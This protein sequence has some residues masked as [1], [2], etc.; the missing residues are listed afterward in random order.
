MDE[1]ISVGSGAQSV[2]QP[3]SFHLM[4]AGQIV[5][6]LGSSLLRF[7]LSLYVLDLTGRADLFATL[8][9]IS[10]IPLLLAPIGGAISD[11]FN[12]QRLMVLYDGLCCAIALVFLLVMGSGNA[13]VFAIGVVMVLLGIVGA[14][15]T[16]N[17]TACVPLLVH[18][19]KLESSNGLIQ[20]VQSLSGIIAPVLGGIL[21]GALGITSL[22]VISCAAFGLAAMMEL[23]IKIPFEK[24]PQTGGM[25]ATIARDLKDG[26][27]YV[28][29]ESL[30]R[31]IAT[32][33]ALINLVIA[34]C[35]IVA[36]PLVL[37][38]IMGAD[39]TVY[40]IGMGLIQLASI[41]GALTVGLF[42]KKMQFSTLWRW[43]A[44]VALLF[45][46]AALSIASMTLGIGFWPPFV[47]FMLCVILIAA[48]LTI[49]NIFAI[50]RVQAQTPAQNLG[51]VMAIMMAVAQC[52]APIGQ[53][54]YG[55]AFEGFRSVAFLPLLLAGGVT[56]LIAL[57]GRKI[58][59]NEKFDND[60][61]QAKNVV[62]ESAAV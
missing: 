5:T 23:F 1:M 11:R 43:M 4:V 30:I 41:G 12:R 19:S 14:M 36:A 27:A 44:V 62:I 54:V 58:F 25:A 8:F 50:V 47:L 3:A 56:L 9:A 33:A 7:A 6:V 42:S 37:R 52:A 32:I 10:S 49:L 15:E 53:F 22:V 35:L 13:S 46:P 38:T 48:T 18:E 34:P 55:V 40:G 59:E 17:G 51:K 26:F 24:R 39:D 20:A 31:K 60:T 16:P 2:P 45:V 29:K 61:L 21:Y 57:V 28:W